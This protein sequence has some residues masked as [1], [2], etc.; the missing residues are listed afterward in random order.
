MKSSDFPPSR[1]PPIRDADPYTELHASI[2]GI[3]HAI[4][5]SLDMVES[6]V[7]VGVVVSQSLA[8]GR[9]LLAHHEAESTVLFPVLRRAG[10]LRSTDAAFL[11]GCDRAHHEL[12]GLCERLVAV[13]SSAHPSADGMKALARELAGAFSSHVRDEERGLAP[14]HLKTMLGLGDLAVLDR[15]LEAFRQRYGT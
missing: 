1:P 5:G 9:F 8:A 4:I 6:A 7:G 2:V 15:E 3:H 12:H 13:A 11:D 14:E 10:K